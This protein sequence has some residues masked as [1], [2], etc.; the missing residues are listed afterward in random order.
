[1]SGLFIT[2]EGGE[3]AGKT[4][5]ANAVI[6]KLSTLGIETLYTREPGGIKIAEKIRE[7]IL[8]RDHTEMDCR[9]EALLYAAARRQHLVEK[10]KPA[11]D[12]GR[13]V[14]CDRFVD[15]SIVYQ[16]Y[17]RGIGMD[18]VREINQFAIEGFMPDL[19]IF[20]DIKPE[21]GLARIAA[22]DSRE[23]NRL[24]LEGLAFHE[25]VYE[26]YK[27]QAKMNPERIV[28]VDATKSVEALTDE[29]CALILSK[30]NK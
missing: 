7:V 12:E 8:D 15:S 28:S 24:D 13:I 6:D 17:A 4:T 19:T 21:I 26:G 27:K 14:L 5:I 20:F 23:V 16:G 9:T 29:V 2:L 30:L 11:M 18:E 22:N 1:M 3:G 25:L 10:V